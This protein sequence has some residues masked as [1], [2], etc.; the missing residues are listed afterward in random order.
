MTAQ[1]SETIV[2]KGEECRLCSFPL[3]PLLEEKKIKF[4]ARH[5]GCW[6]G[7]HAYWLIEDNRL[8]L[9]DFSG[10]I[11]N[12]ESVGIDYI[13]PEHSEGDKI[14]ADWYTGELRITKGKMLHYIHLGFASIYEEDIIIEIENG[15]VKNETVI[16]ND[17]NTV[18]KAIRKWSFFGED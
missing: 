1:V 6:R 13:F 17:E 12:F 9:T 10:T 4:K 5:T 18:K 16:K 15:I 14:F 8:Y 3:N 11:E 7:Y 2:Y